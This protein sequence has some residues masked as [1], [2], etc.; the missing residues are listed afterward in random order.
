MIQC[1]DKC[2]NKSSVPVFNERTMVVALS[3]ENIP[4]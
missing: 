4:L 2:Y 3:I 1:T